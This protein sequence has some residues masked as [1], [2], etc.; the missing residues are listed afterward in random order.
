[1]TSPPHA[2]K[3][4]VVVMG[5]S[6]S[7]KTTIGKRLAGKLG[8]E[9][10]EGD[11]FHPKPNIDKMSRGEP[12]TDEDRWPWLAA[13][14]RRIDQARAERRGLVVACSALKRA[15]RDILIGTRRDVLLVYLRGSREVIGER[16]GSRKHEYMPPSLLPSQFAALEEPGP[17]ERP[18]AIDVAKPAEVTVDE[19][20]T[21]IETSA[22]RR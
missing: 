8:V 11:D 15:Y 6:G 22:T 16:V 9:F 14:A 13:I 17:D 12:L 5:V 10:A 21:A 4:V 18:I 1:M 2:V 19:A 3:P 20:V 7:G